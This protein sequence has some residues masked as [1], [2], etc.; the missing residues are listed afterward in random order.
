MV[1][2]EM[3][4][5][6]RAQRI[7]DALG[8]DLFAGLMSPDGTLLEANVSVMIATGLSVES[9][10][11]QRFDRLEC[12]SY[13]ESVQERL[14]ES[15][16]QAAA[17]TPCRYDVQLRLADGSLR[18]I[19]FSLRPIRD[20]HGIVTHLVPSA[21]NIDERKRAEEALRE[22]EF[23]F[24][25]LAASIDDVF[26]LAEPRSLRILYVSPAY[27]RMW[28]RKCEDLY[29]SPREWMQAIHKDDLP[30]IL[31][32]LERPD[33][34]I[35]EEFRM[36]RPDGS[37]RWIQSQMFPIRDDEGRTYRIAGIAR[38]ITEGKLAV[39]ERARF[40]ALLNQTDKLRALGTLAG[41]IAHDFN[42]ILAIINGYSSLIA[43]ELPTDHPSQDRLSIVRRAARRGTDLVRQILTFSR[44]RNGSRRIVT[45]LQPVIE[46]A[47]KLVRATL[48]AM[49]EIDTQ[50]EQGLP[51]IEIDPGQIHQVVMNLCT[52]AAH[53]I[54]DA[55]GRI[56]LAVDTTN[57]SEAQAAAID[58]KLVAG[59]YVRLS[60]KDNGCGMEPQTVRRVFEPFFTTK[61]PGVGTGLGLSVV[62]GIAKA[63]GGMIT[64]QSALGDGSTFELFFPAVSDPGAL[65][66]VQWDT[67]T[68]AC[69]RGE[70]VLYVDDDESMA[71]LMREVL[72]RQNYRVTTAHHARE[73]LEI[74]AEQP[75][76]FDVVV[77][78]LAMPG[79]SGLEMADR[80]HA[81]RPEL[82]IVLNSGY[83][84]EDEDED[85]ATAHPGLRRVLLKPDS[86]HELGSILRD[87]C[88]TT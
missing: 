87:V 86:I 28:G 48:P 41:G 34:V 44:P 3:T 77:T 49:I 51:D 32:N 71:E 65:Q 57:L 19:D 79:M 2:R 84:R 53:A 21:V 70:R 15:I 78:D 54:G 43:R 88:G 9:T 20:T 68:Q 37:V 80:L 60:V 13:S 22:S 83:F 73:A 24:R 59:R 35:T 85:A 12:W 25:Q 16:A 36:T 18:W 76:A 39:E 61:E 6:K 5:P 58:P 72:E 75:N 40:E 63:Q 23:R 26:W 8:P 11:G 67:P 64:V 38:D 27:E 62:Y 81:M 50:F 47:L 29:R 17:G 46:D 10:I 69:G 52:N 7:L 30:R 56:T 33:E 82:P 66:P 42:N 74:F 45:Q 4:D 14:R 55:T 1:Q 31:S